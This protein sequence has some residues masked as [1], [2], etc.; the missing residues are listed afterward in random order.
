MKHLSDVIT[1]LPLDKV[2][3]IKKYNGKKVAICSIDECDKQARFII[4]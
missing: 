2:I 1:T 3:K 4:D